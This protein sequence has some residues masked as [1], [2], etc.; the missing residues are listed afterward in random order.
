M[1][2]ARHSSSCDSSHSTSARSFARPAARLLASKAARPMY[3][4]CRPSTSNVRCSAYASSNVTPSILV[5]SRSHSV[6]LRF[7][8]HSPRSRTSLRSRRGRQPARRRRPARG[9]RA[10][11]S[12]GPVARTRPC[13]PCLGRGHAE[14]AP[15]RRRA[16][17][18]SGVREADQQIAVVLA[19]TNFSHV[20]SEKPAR[21][22]T[23]GA[24]P[25]FF[26]PTRATDS[27][28]TPSSSRDAPQRSGPSTAPVSAC[29]PV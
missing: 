26:R 24:A 5:S 29:P 21:A 14:R 13:R 22:N 28:T 9:K 17:F 2:R 15:I 6:E 23:R 10:P 16:G 4:I 25:R 19:Q 18:R 8:I 20:R 3:A 12:P 1:I 27:G 7:D 11:R